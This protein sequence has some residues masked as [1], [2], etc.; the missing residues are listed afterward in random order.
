MKG[1][2]ASRALAARRAVGA[3]GNLALEERRRMATD[4]GA[5]VAAERRRV[6]ACLTDLVGAPVQVYRSPYVRSASN[7]EE[8]S[9]A[10][11]DGS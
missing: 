9:T 7:G 1:V 11:D 10:R 5:R 4:A 8:R 6:E 3:A 2:L